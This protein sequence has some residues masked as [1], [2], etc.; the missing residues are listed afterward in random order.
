MQHSPFSGFDWYGTRKLAASAPADGIWYTTRPGALIAVKL[1]WWSDGFKL[2]MESELKV[3]IESLHGNPSSPEILE[4]T[5]AFR[6]ELRLSGPWAMLVGIDIP[7]PG[8][9]KIKGEFQKESLEFVVD[10]LDIEKLR[11]GQ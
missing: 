5:N 6:G 2:G 4:T 11:P 10:V 9:W 7:A 3:E 8:C 1:F